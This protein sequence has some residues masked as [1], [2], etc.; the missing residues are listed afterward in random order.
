MGCIPLFYLY[1][2]RLGQIRFNYFVI[3]LNHALTFYVVQRP[4]SFSENEKGKWV[5]QNSFFSRF[6]P[7]NSG[8]LLH[9]LMCL[10]PAMGLRSNHYVKPRQNGY[11]TYHHRNRKPFVEHQIRGY[12]RY[13]RIQIYVIGRNQ[14]TNTLGHFVPHGITEQRGYQSQKQQ[15]P[16]N[17]R[18]RQQ[19][20]G[21][22]VFK[23]YTGAMLNMP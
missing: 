1:Y 16:P 3:K 14:G 5:F 22:G 8:H 20:P 13:Q 17:H 18:G 11:A 21:N 9:F 4:Y 12:T 23:P 6:S 19:L 10:F 15:I 2:G 7:I